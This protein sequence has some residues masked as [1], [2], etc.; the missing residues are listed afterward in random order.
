MT[1]LKENHVNQDREWFDK[2]IDVWLIRENLKLSFEER[3]AQ[4]ENMLSLINELNE[5]GRK[6]RAKSSGLTQA[7]HSK[8]R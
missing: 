1:L 2:G 5:I 3:I 4:H 6:N 7:T 8:S